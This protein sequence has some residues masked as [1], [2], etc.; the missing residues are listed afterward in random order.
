M[1]TPIAQARRRRADAAARFR[2][3]HVSLLLVNEAP[4]AALDRYFYFEDVEIHDSLF[5]HVAEVVL[6]EKPTRDKAPYLDELRDRGVFLIDFAI[7]PIESLDELPPKVP[8]L[9]RRCRAIDP[10]HIVLIK[11]ST[12]DYA[13]DALS[14]AGLP[15]ID[16][17]IPFPGSGQ[18]TRFKDLFAEVLED[19]PIAHVTRPR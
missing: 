13:Y 3:E 5:R 9:V 4:P 12:Y 10:E 19:L 6:G 2:P 14:A 8:D 7:D 15:L 11:V 18:Q 16:A 1:T 17:R